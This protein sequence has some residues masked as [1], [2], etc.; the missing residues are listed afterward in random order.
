L[1]AAAERLEQAAASFE[2]LGLDGAAA[3]ARDGERDARATL[4]EEG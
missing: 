1:E 3:P 2:R 4:R